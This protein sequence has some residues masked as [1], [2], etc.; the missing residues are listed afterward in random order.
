MRGLPG[1]QQL[2]DRPFAALIMSAINVRP[3]TANRIGHGE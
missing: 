1:Q 2:E 3:G